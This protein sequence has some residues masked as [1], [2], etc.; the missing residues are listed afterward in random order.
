MTMVM[1]SEEVG[2]VSFR[3]A[4]VISERVGT[5]TGA[6]LLAFRGLSKGKPMR[7]VSIARI[8]VSCDGSLGE[9]GKSKS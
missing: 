6:T 1:M 3:N 5:G 8:S 7:P 9:V 2:A 4:L